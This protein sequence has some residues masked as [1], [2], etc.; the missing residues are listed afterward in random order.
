MK[1]TYIKPNIKVK[2]IQI[3]SM[4]AASEK[5][6]YGAGDSANN[7]ESNSR[8]GRWGDLWSNEEED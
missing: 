6:N 3:Q 7:A 5:L 1:T 2:N 4:L 8:R